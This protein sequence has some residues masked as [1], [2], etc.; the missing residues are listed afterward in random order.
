MDLWISGSTIWIICC[1]HF[2]NVWSMFFHQQLKSSGDIASKAAEMGKLFAYVSRTEVSSLGFSDLKLACDSPDAFNIVPSS[3]KVSIMGP[4][5]SAP[6]LLRTCI[7]HLGFAASL[8]AG[9]D[10]CIKDKRW[11]GYSDC[12]QH[13]LQCRLLW[14]LGPDS[15]H[16]YDS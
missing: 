14:T 3:D 2:S 5:R 4:C 12:L 11:D 9:K 16:G 10:A 8:S 1:S 13:R 6:V 7:I 15:S